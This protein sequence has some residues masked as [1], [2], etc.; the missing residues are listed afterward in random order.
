MSPKTI[1]YETLTDA[2]LKVLIDCASKQLKDKFN[3]DVQ[4]IYDEQPSDKILLIDSV[5]DVNSSTISE[6]LGS[7]KILLRD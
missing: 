3:L 5:T 4:E 7:I 2:E 6:E 1:P